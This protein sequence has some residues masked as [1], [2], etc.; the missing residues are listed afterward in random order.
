MERADLDRIRS[1]RGPREAIDISGLSL[2][3]EGQRLA[4]GRGEQIVALQTVLREG[5][6]VVVGPAVE[7]GDLIALSAEALSSERRQRFGARRR[8]QHGPFVEVRPDQQRGSIALAGRDRLRQ[9][10][11]KHVSV[12][13]GSEPE[14]DRVSAHRAKE[15]RACRRAGPRESPRPRGA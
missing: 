2:F 12:H 7:L 6:A 3:R 8:K 4:R 10:M 1:R 9:V 15:V 13:V 11:R 14:R 5:S